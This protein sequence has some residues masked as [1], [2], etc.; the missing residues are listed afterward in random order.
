ML[1]TVYYVTSSRHF[2]SMCVELF[3]NQ[4]KK[5]KTKTA[6]AKKRKRKREERIVPEMNQFRDNFRVE[7]VE[8]VS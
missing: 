3:M 1:R 6:A 5:T 7:N 2:C 4:E 8:R